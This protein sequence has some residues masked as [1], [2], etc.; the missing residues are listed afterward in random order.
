V[1]AVEMDEAVKES[2]NEKQNSAGGTHDAAIV[3]TNQSNTR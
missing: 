2:R 1:I 3:G